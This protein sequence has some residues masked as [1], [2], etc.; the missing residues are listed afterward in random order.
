MTMKEKLSAIGMWAASAPTMAFGFSTLVSGTTT[1]L[2]LITAVLGTGMAVCGF[3]WW[4]R[5]LKRQRVRMEIEEMEL[6]RLRS[7]AS[8]QSRHRGEV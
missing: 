3:I 6:A 8:H 1:L 4:V 5:R 7:L 2:G